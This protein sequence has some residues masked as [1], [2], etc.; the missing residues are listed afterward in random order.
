MVAKDGPGDGPEEFEAGDGEGQLPEELRNLSPEELE[1]V[2]EAMAQE[3]SEE[4]TEMLDGVMWVLCQVEA[5]GSL[6]Q[7]EQMGALTEAPDEIAAMI[8]SMVPVSRG[9]ED[10]APQAET[11]WERFVEDMK[12]ANGP[13]FFEKVRAEMEAEEDEDGEE[14]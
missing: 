13:D 9:G 11:E 2:A 14:E 12:E 6:K 8:R 5:A 3:L 7:A 10:A 1:E 4:D